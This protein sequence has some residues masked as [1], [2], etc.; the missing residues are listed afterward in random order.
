MHHRWAIEP[1]RRAIVLLVRA[2]FNLSVAGV[3]FWAGT[4]G[5]RSPRP[6]AWIAAAGATFLWT[7]AFVF[8]DRLRDLHPRSNAQTALLRRFRV[9]FAGYLV[10]C[11]LFGI[12]SAIYGGAIGI[13]GAFGGL[14]V[15]SWCVWTLQQL[16]KIR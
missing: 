16:A 15:G 9:Q 12:G 6:N 3:S 13:V 14:F 1:H 11:C 5:L 4:F 2:V 10:A 7:I 8:V